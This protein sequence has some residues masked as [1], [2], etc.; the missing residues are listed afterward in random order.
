MDLL[1]DFEEKLTLSENSKAYLL[2]TAKWGKFLAILGFV[3][4]GLIAIVA[5]SAGTIM[6]IVSA[7]QSGLGA[8]GGQAIA[9]MGGLVTVIYLGI[10]VLY[11]FPNFYLFKF[12]SQVKNAILDSDNDSLET[13]LSNLKSVYKFKGIMTAIVVGFYALILV[14]ALLAGGIGSMMR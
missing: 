6:S 10:A 2:E 4:C 3:M 13:A 11:F 9:G 1:A 12:S 7:S 14:F 5:F 8:P